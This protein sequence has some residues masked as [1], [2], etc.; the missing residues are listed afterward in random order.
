[1]VD[2]LAVER[3]L[4]VRYVTQLWVAGVRGLLVLP[5]RDR[6]VLELGPGFLP[7]DTDSLHAFR[8]VQ[9]IWQMVQLQCSLK[10]WLR[11]G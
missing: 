4:D 5:A 6:N 2:S 8:E 7:L 9:P 1:M 11:S 3:S 10:Q